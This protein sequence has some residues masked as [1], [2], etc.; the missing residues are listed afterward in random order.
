M[1]NKLSDFEKNLYK[2]LK[3]GKLEV[4]VSY[5]TFLCP[6]C[7]DNKKK[8]GLYVDILQHASGVGNS[9]SK[10]RSLTEKASHRAL[11]KYL[12]KDLAHYATSTI[13][14]RLKARTSFIPAETGDAPIIYD[15]AQ[16]EKLVWPWKGNDDD[17][18]SY[19][20]TSIVVLALFGFIASLLTEVVSV[21]WLG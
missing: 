10:K 16:F 21:V 5:R 20:I 3:S 17:A 14:K 13:S 15:D 12:I 11:A 1:N 4:K 6:Y 2:K 7:P 18:Y 9:Q 8:V 19:V